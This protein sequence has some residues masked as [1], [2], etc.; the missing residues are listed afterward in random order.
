M[1]KERRKALMEVV[2]ELETLKSINGKSEALEL[3]YQAKEDIGDCLIDEKD[4][5]EKM[6]E[7]ISKSPQIDAFDKHIADMEDAK[8]E[9]EVAIGELEEL[10]DMD[11][12]EIRIGIEF[13]I[14]KLKDAVKK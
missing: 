4:C 6:L 8:A 13:S 2:E 5:L 1:N 11:Y 14:G 7:R 12:E 3:L 10:T 9:V